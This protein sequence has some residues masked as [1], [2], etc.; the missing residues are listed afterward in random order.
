MALQMKFSIY[1]PRM[2][3]MSQSTP[4][5]LLQVTQQPTFLVTTSSHESITCL[6]YLTPHHSTYRH[7]KRDTVL[8]CTTCQ[9]HHLPKQPHTTS[10]NESELLMM[11][12][13]TPRCGFMMPEATITPDSLTLCSPLDVS[14][15]TVT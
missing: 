13:W 8:M 6:S 5:D 10:P 14:F 3:Q 2:N 1:Q 12:T 9:H 7:S 15:S 11:S 4:A